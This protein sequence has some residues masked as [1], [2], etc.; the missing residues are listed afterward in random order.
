M[1]HELDGPL[2]QSGSIGIRYTPDEGLTSSNLIFFFWAFLVLSAGAGCLPL[3]RLSVNSLSLAGLFVAVLVVVV[4]VVA[5]TESSADNR[6][7]S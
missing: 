2:I 6:P 5:S 4:V 7:H 3:L 1:F